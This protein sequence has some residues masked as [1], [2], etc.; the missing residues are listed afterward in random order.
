MTFRKQ[1][2]LSLNKIPHRWT[3]CLVE[4]GMGTSL[5]FSGG[6]HDKNLMVLVKF[7]LKTTALAIFPMLAALFLPNPALPYV[8]ST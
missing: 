8:V 1:C 6:S 4:A 5:P 3:V 7:T 2:K